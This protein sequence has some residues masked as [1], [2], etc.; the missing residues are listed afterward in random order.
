MSL[1]PRF[2]SL[3][4][5]RENSLSREVC[6]QENFLLLINHKSAALLVITD[7]T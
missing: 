3:C 5:R 1:S 6:D 7:E 2:H 4:H